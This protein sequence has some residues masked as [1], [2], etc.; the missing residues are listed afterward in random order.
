MF[1]LFRYYVMS[2]VMFGLLR[3]A[4]LRFASLRVFNTAGR[5]NQLLVNA[6]MPVSEQTFKY[7]MYSILKLWKVTGV[8]ARLCLCQMPW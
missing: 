6:V 8:C 5:P 1:A 7:K 3:F 2:R 4:G